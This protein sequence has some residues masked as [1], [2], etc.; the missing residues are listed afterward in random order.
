MHEERLLK[1]AELLETKIEK[2]TFDIGVFYEEWEGYKCGY[3]ACAV[4]HAMCDPW[5]KRR[6]FTTY[7][8]SWRKI[9]GPLNKKTGSIGWD[10]VEE[11]FDI[12]NEE[13]DLLFTP[14]SYPEYTYNPTP[15]QVAKRIRK[16]VKEKKKDE[17]TAIA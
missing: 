12:N 1:L 3:A 17:R 2:R 15:K 13:S 7:E 11:F 4:G 14:L 6:G 10:A 8:S 5:F 9:A 16:F